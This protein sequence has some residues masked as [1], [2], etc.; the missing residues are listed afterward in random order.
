MPSTGIILTRRETLLT[1]TEETFHSSFARVA[2]ATR[3]HLDRPSQLDSVSC[4]W[5][6]FSWFDSAAEHRPAPLHSPV[7]ASDI[8]EREAAKPTAAGSV[9]ASPD[10]LLV[11]LPLPALVRSPLVALGFASGTDRTETLVSR[12]Q[13]SILIFTL[14]NN[15]SITRLFAKHPAMTGYQDYYASL[16]ST[17]KHFH[18]N[19][20]IAK[21]H[22]EI[23]LKTFRTNILIN[24]PSK[25][26]LFIRQI[27]IPTEMSSCHT[28]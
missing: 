2:S 8:C 27:T 23:P 10:L 21:I 11:Q 18:S 3:S 4:G 9:C 13:V 17:L 25:N 28:W 6:H 24:K 1:N 19:L 26:L 15:L 14:Y 16:C 7:H 22:W 12:L 20:G 5:E